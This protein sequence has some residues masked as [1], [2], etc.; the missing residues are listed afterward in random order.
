[1]PTPVSSSPRADTLAEEDLRALQAEHEALVHDCRVA[2]ERV[3]VFAGEKF[4]ITGTAL[5]PMMRY[6]GQRKDESGQVALA[7]LHRILEECLD[8]EAFRR[9]QNAAIDTKASIEE[10]TEAVQQVIEIHC[11]YPWQAA[12]RLLGYAVFNLGELEGHQLTQSGRGLGELTPRQL[13]NLS[14]AVLIH[15]RDEEQRQEF[16]EDLYLDFDPAAEAKRQ[17]L[18]MIASKEEGARLDG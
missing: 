3:V 18:E 8:A 12:L 11:A 4:S 17:V 16:L 13:C 6:A 1:M 9:F 15:G 10:V 2:F 14:L 7:S 5:V